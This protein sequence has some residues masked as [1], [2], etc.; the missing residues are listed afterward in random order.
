MEICKTGAEHIK[1]LQDGRAVYIDGELVGDVTTHRAFRNSVASACALYDFQA[2]P[3]NIE[4]MTFALDGAN[5]RV[6]RGWQIPRSSSAS[7][8]CFSQSLST[9]SVSAD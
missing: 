5:R 1:S 9:R 8:N 2:A 3:E 4:L 7:I 6:N